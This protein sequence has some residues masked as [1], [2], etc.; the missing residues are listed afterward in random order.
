M[1]FGN[2]TGMAKAIDYIGASIIITLTTFVWSVLLFKNTAGALVFSVALSLVTV[3]SIRYFSKKKQ[4]PYTYDRLESEFCMRGGEYVIELIVSA[5]KNPKIENG[6]NYILLENCIIIANFKFSPL[7]GSDIANICKTAKAY[8]KN[9]VFLLTK[10]VDRKAWQVAYLQDV[11]IEIV[12]TKQVFRFLAKHNAL[13]ALKKPKQKASVRAVFETVFSR[14]NFKN[15]LF[16]GAVVIFTSFFTPLK[17]YYIV[18]GTILFALA[19][20]TLTPVGNGNISSPKVFDQ[21][22][23]ACEDE[24]VR[25]I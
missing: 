21:L 13:P 3:L 7:G 11:K 9:S 19:L 10:S 5:L 6:S 16:S 15:Y 1:S 20:L 14:K 18:V 2:N 8:Q 23:K 17:I 12:K 24:Y 22:D 25:E 4:K